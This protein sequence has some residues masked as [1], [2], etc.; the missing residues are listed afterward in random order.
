MSNTNN[1]YI[2]RM[3]RILF[4]IE[5]LG[6]YCK[7]CHL[8]G[9][10]MPTV[11]DFHHIDESNKKYEVKNYLYNGSFES[12]KEEVDKCILICSNCHRQNH[13]NNEQFQTNHDQILIKLEEIKNNNGSKITKNKFLSQIEKESI[14]DLVNSGLSIKNISDKL[15]LNYGTV[16]SFIKRNKLNPE[17]HIRIHLPESLIIKLLNSKYSIRGIAKKLNINR[18][19]VRLFISNKVIYDTLDNNV[20]IYKKK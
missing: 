19:S 10:E 7:Y 12:H 16:K 15:D 6:R 5:Y 14:L 4:A 9:F 18:E 3:A 1:D 11:M 2:R 13:S 20:R 17:K 8:D